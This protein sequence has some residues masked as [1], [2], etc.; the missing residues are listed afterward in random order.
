MKYDVRQVL[1]QIAQSDQ[2][3]LIGTAAAF[4]QIAAELNNLVVPPKHWTWNYLH[5]VA[6]GR[7]KP[8]HVLTTAIM[9]L[10]SIL[11]I[12]THQVPNFEN[13]Q[14]FAPAGFITPGTIISTTS[15]KCFSSLCDRNFV[16]SHP[17]QR[18]CNP[19]CRRQFHRIH[20]QTK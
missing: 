7:L 10:Q 4:R 3:R 18:F 12:R 1:A 5:Q 15:R 14:V 11:K 2:Y 9:R 13:T 8:S 19:E 6:H 16:P 17:R 20:G